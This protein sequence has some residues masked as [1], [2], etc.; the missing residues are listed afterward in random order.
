VAAAHPSANAASLSAT[1][2]YHVVSEP[3]DTSAECVMTPF[4][5]LSPSGSGSTSARDRSCA[6]TVHP[7]VA[8]RRR[9]LAPGAVL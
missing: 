9:V 3:A 1:L 4:Q 7:W 2:F 8:T 5:S 6:R